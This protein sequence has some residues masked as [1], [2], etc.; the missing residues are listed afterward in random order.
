MPVQFTKTL[1]GFFLADKQAFA[2]YLGVTPKCVTL[3][4]QKGEAPDEYAK[5]VEVLKRVELFP[6]DRLPEKCAIDPTLVLAFD[7]LRTGQEEV[8]NALATVFLDANAPQWRTG[9]PHLEDLAVLQECFA[10]LVKCIAWVR[11][12]ESKD[13]LEALTFVPSLRRQLTTHMKDAGI[14]PLHPQWAEW[15]YLAAMVYGYWM[16]Y[17]GERF[18][19]GR[20]DHLVATRRVDVANYVL[21]HAARIGALELARALP[22]VSH[23]RSFIAF[24][25]IQFAAVAKDTFTFNRCLKVLAKDYRNLFFRNFI[26]PTLASDDDTSVMLELPEVDDYIERLLQGGSDGLAA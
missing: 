21:K 9:T 8:A 3:W 10:R 17:V 23:A 14:H 15:S 16:S 7:A 12:A 4:L 13:N 25:L 5:K 2:D 1:F 22:K 18:K 24:N 20:D 26:L 19:M 6:L 11:N